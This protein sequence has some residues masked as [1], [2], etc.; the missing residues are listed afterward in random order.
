MNKTSMSF[1]GKFV[2]VACE[3]NTVS[4]PSEEI[5]IEI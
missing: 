1:Q 5:I 3:P 4:F 2:Y